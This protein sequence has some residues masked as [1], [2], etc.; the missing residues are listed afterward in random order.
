MQIFRD[1]SWEILIAFFVV[2][3]VIPIR[4]PAAT[5]WPYAVREVRSLD[6]ILNLR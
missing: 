6:E 4:F 5:P 3:R 1:F 2:L